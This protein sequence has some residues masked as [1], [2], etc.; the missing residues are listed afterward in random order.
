MSEK[1]N[2][3][4]SEGWHI[5]IFRTLQQIE[6]IR[7]V[8]EQLQAQQEN[9]SVNADI[10]R[11]RSVL[12]AS[13]GQSAP[14]IILLKHN[15]LPKAMIIGRQEKHTIPIRIGYK[16]I[17]KPQLNCLTVVYGGILGHIDENVSTV[18]LEKCKKILKEQKLDIIFFNHL[19]TDC[20][21]LKHLYKN[22]RFI[23]RNH[24]PVVE[25]HWRMRIPENIEAFFELR[26]KKHRKH[27]RHYQNKIKR[28]FPDRIAYCTY[29]RPSE[30]KQAVE[31]AASVSQCS[32]QYAMGAG[33]KYLQ[34][35][36]LLNTAATKGWFRGHI[37]SIDNQPA[38]FRFALRYRRIYFGDGIGYNSRWGDFRIGTI[39]FLRVLEQL[40]GE[41]EVDYYDFGFGDADYKQSYGSESWPEVA[42]TYLFAPR[43][44]PVL[45][46][47][48]TSFNTGC[49]RGLSAV[50]RRIRIFS[51]IKRLW[52]RKLKET[53][54]KQV[55][56]N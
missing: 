40:C 28:A 6:S 1:F 43:L 37:L 52:R 55:E 46:N 41:R 44:Y 36:I 22:T 38:A 32:Y 7:T 24:F 17:F 51:T 31:D 47:L 26:S 10:D 5:D 15:S 20:H 42:A 34:Q 4:L 49:T 18:L 11:Y 23:S 48:M 16:A 30:V 25:L 50:F 27:L 39:L 29:S 8:W 56:E 12:E 14:L 9:P 3:L 45:I 53:A 2:R 35:S 13:Q 19:K 33:F 54:L 21:L